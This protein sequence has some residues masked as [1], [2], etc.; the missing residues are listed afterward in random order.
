MYPTTSDVVVFGAACSCPNCHTDVE[1][2][3]QPYGDVCHEF[4]IIHDLRSK[5]VFVHIVLFVDLAHLLGV[6]E[7]Q[8]HKRINGTLLRKPEPKRVACEVNAI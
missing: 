4:Q 3:R 8:H 2:K 5:L 7:N 6:P 1:R